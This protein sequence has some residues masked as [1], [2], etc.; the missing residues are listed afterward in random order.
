MP[1]LL[2]SSNDILVLRAKNHTN[3]TCEILYRSESCHGS[4][5]TKTLITSMMAETLMN[6][7][8]SCKVLSSLYRP[9]ISP[10]FCACVCLYVCV[11]VFVCVCVFVCIHMA[12]HMPNT[13]FQSI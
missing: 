7:R 10:Y 4:A 11:F 8:H 1:F 12:I 6:K 13:G 2:I 5:E 9:V 3:G